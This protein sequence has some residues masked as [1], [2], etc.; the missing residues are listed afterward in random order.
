MFLW[1]GLLDILVRLSELIL[2]LRVSTIWV[3]LRHNNKWANIS[4]M[5]GK[6]RESPFEP[7][8]APYPKIDYPLHQRWQPNSFFLLKHRSFMCSVIKNCTTNPWELRTRSCNLCRIKL[9]HWTFLL[10]AGCYKCA[11]RLS[12]M[13]WRNFHIFIYLSLL[14][15]QRK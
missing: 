1:K 5:Y 12:L 7:N 11:S 9:V 3:E 2:Q 15:I 4:K 10:L 14:D 8:S 13:S 6:V